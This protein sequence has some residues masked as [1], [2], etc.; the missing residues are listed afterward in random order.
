MKPWTVFAAVGHSD[1]FGSR[2]ESPPA[3]SASQPTTIPRNNPQP[4]D[5]LTLTELFDEYFS[6]D[7]ALTQKQ[8]NHAYRIRYDVY[9]KE[10]NYEDCENHADER[11]VDE[12]DDSSL[13]CL[14][15]H[16]F[17][18]TPAACVRLVPAGTDEDTGRLPLEKYCAESLDATFVRQLELDRNTVCEI[19]RLAV[20][21]LFRRRSHETLSYFG[22]ID[23]GFSREEQ[24]TFPLVAVA[25]FLGA[26]ALA[27]VSG[28]DNIFAMMEPF[29][30]RLLKR[31]GIVFQMAGKNIEY[32][33]LRA[34]YF[35]TTQT[36]L[37][38]L[39]PDIRVLYEKI[40]AQI[41][42]SYRPPG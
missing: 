32:H 27:E 38:G 29:L 1:I 21:G 40:K 37:S 4:S 33:G 41:L 42:Q 23:T 39:K 11:E 26:A 5:G 31:S 13:H 35:I 2:S 3:A 7:L 6:V 10:F 16:R 15:T 22:D 19:S 24:R 28:R 14:I 34:P 25:S 9:C 8:K 17:S 30:P 20:D 12:F 36:V 18:K